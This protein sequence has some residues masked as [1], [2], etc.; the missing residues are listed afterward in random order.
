VNKGELIEALVKKT[1]LSKAAAG[2]A[3]DAFI[4]IVTE[5]VAKK[6]DVQLIGF[7]TF[8]SSK[9]AARTGRNP[10]TG[11]TIKIAASTVP[12]FKP[13]AAF[14]AALNKKK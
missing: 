11:A 8:T 5:N 1:E 12:K 14:K 10:S 2:R 7:G 3:V 9:R 4:D 13:G 6:K